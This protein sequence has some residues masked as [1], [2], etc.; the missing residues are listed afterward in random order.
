MLHHLKIPRKY[1]L[2]NVWAQIW[3]RNKKGIELIKHLSTG[4]GS[5]SC[6]NCSGHTFCFA[7][8][9]TSSAR[10]TGTRSRSS[11]VPG[12]QLSNQLRI[13]TSC[14]KSYYFGI[15][16]ANTSIH[17][18]CRTYFDWYINKRFEKTQ[19]M[20]EARAN[21][22][23][24]LE[25]LSFD[26]KAVK[27]LPLDNSVDPRVRRP[28]TGACFTSVNQEPLENPETVAYSSDAL[29]LL[30]IAEDEISKDD[31]PEY[32]S[33]SKILPGSSPAAHCYCGHQFGYFSGQLGDGAAM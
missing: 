28:V 32:F 33:G 26:N 21:R 12:C 25:N 7:R 29:S 8:S 16:P 27:E 23:V 18:G 31:F 10:V 13:A 5:G 6:L 2:E 30:D 9:A 1:S 22:T 14:Q 20:A 4:T 19:T 17:Q 15:L 11:H 3:Q 24:T